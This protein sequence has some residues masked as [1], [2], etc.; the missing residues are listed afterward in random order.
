MKQKIY[1][2][3]IILWASVASLSCNSE[4]E[5]EPEPEPIPEAITLDVSVL[6]HQFE[7]N[8]KLSLPVTVKS[9][10]SFEASSSQTWCV[11]EIIEENETGNLIITVSENKS[12]DERS[13]TVT[14]ATQSEGE[15]EEEPKTVLI[16]IT[17]SGTEPSLALEEGAIYIVGK[18]EE[19]T[20][21]VK[22]NFPIVFTFPAWIEPQAPENDSIYTF[23]AGELPASTGTR[24]GNLVAKAVNPEIT[25]TVSIPVVQTNNPSLNVMTY[26]I[27]LES[28]SLLRW[29][30]R[31]NAMVQFIRLN[32]P[33]IIGTQETEYSQHTFLQR[34]LTEYAL[35]GVG[36]EDGKTN[37]EHNTIL[38]K[39]GRFTECCSGTFW[40]SENPDKP[41]KGWDA[42]YTRIA[43]Y[44]ILTDKISGKQIFVINTHI[45]THIEQYGLIAQR[46]SIPLLM[47]KISELHGDLPVVL[48]GDFNMPPT[49]DNIVY[50][51]DASGGHYSLLHT[52]EIS[53]TLPA[54]NVGTY[55]ALKDTAPGISGLIDYIFVDEK[56]RVLAYTVFP[57]KFEGSFLSDHSAVMAKIEIK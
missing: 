22:A 1:A 46:E 31:R 14:I 55:H 8:K 2:F 34:N 40:L 16:K 42:R 56:V 37:G 4:P 48:T 51:T 19:F 39:K 38:Y 45:E 9:N 43:S 5:A 41:G 26:N 57:S 50:I 3:A 29:S 54:G 13:A 6:E 44:L 20:V 17:Q 21:H 10:R 30:D 15:N 27:Y 47:R 33:D 11:T 7:A 49:N 52:K 25:D 53:E 12:I 36:R 23:V 32:D 24:K 28:G 18:G 35:Y